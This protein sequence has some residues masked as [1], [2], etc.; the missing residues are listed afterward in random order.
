MVFDTRVRAD[1]DSRA[2]DP[3]AAIA[4]AVALLVRMRDEIDATVHKLEDIARETPPKVDPT[5]PTSDPMHN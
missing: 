2:M 4:A 3:H 5:K 1:E